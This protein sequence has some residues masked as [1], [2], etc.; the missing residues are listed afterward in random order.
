MKRVRRK[1]ANFMEQYRD[2]KWVDETWK[3][4]EKK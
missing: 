4:I 2:K 3:K 1:G